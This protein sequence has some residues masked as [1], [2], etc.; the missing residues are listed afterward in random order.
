MALFTGTGSLEMLGGDTRI[1]DVEFANGNTHCLGF[2]ANRGYIRNCQFTGVTGIDINGDWV[3]ISNCHFSGFTTGI[4]SDASNVLNVSECWFDSGD[5]GIQGFLDDGSVIANNRF[6]NL[7]TGINLDQGADQTVIA[8]NTMIVT[9]AVYI[10]G[11]VDC[12]IQDNLISADADGIVLDDTPTNSQNNTI[13]GN[14]VRMFSVGAHD[15][16][17]ITGVD[18]TMIT[19]NKIIP[20]GAPRSGINVVT[21]S[22][23]NVVFGNSLGLASA[24]TTADFINAGSATVTAPGGNGQF[25]I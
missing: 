15:G 7:D 5:D 9:R 11:A 22:G 23:N 1:Y 10:D 25:S 16:I 12:S 20:S 4:L 3:N 17:R 13:S 24:Y 18:Q 14:Q 19:G 6:N 2:T 21:G 8:D